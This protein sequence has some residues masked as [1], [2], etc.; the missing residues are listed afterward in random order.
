MLL[1]RAK[2][3]IELTQNLKTKGTQSNIE[4]LLIALTKGECYSNFTDN[5]LLLFFYV[6]SILKI[7]K[8]KKKKYR[9]VQELHSTGMLFMYF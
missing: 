1:V 9:S 5:C 7:S 2:K 8:A 3:D 6:T 4:V